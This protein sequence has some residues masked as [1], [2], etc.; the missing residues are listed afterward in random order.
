MIEKLY[1]SGG[2]IDPAW[3]RGK[4]KRR[5]DEESRQKC[6]CEKQGGDVSEERCCS[7][8]AKHSRT[9]TPTARAHRFLAAQAAQAALAAQT[10]RTV[11]REAEEHY[12]DKGKAVRGGG[13]EGRQ[14]PVDSRGVFAA[15]RLQ[16][17]QQQRR[18]TS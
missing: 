11:R 6:E 5:G 2:G 17:K 12:C 7:D 8:K 14:V 15:G 18:G 9:W 16:N 10:A 3:G 4:A 1:I 13:S